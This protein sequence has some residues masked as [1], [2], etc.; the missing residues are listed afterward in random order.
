[1]TPVVSWLF[2]IVCLVELYAEHIDLKPLIYTTKPLAMLI[3]QWQWWTRKPA[4]SAWANWIGVG[5]AFGMLG[6]ILLMIPQRPFIAGLGAFLI[7]H[8]FYIMGYWQSNAVGA[9]RKTA[10]PGLAVLSLFVAA[11]AFYLWPHLGALRIPVVAYLTAIAI[12]AGSA[13]LRRTASDASYVWTVIGALFFL[14]S[15]SMLA[16]HLFIG[17][18]PIS[19][20][21]IMATYFVAQYGI[22][23]GMLAPKVTAAPILA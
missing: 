12:M 5:L 16:H 8:I 20:L 4:Q 9:P 10:Y 18:F 14:A 13:V 3:L 6:D 7:G 21:A 2:A 23:R 1:M 22:T 19:R 17:P 11:A 15:D